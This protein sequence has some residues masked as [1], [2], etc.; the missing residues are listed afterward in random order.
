MNEE[1]KNEVEEAICVDQI[2]GNG[3]GIGKFVIGGVAIVAAGIG[4]WLYKKH[5]KDNDDN[6]SD[7]NVVDGNFTVVEG[8]V[9]DSEKE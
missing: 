5:K 3:K 7:P 1:I 8:E 6:D 9:D 2:E 4:A